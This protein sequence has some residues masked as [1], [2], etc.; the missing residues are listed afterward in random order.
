M[1]SEFENVF[2]VRIGTNT[3]ASVEPMHIELFKN[4]TSMKAKQRRYPPKKRFFM[5]KVVKKLELY[6][7]IKPATE[8]QWVLEPLLVPKA[9]L[10]DHR[11]T[12]HLWAMNAVTK[13]MIW[14]MQNLD[15]RGARHARKKGLSFSKL[16]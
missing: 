12:F 3:P 6:G 13:Q 15:F 9:P 10:T 4:L 1:T 8:K 16:F 5:E 7:F 14:P 2:C 11:M